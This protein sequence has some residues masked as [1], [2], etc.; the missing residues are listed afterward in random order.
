MKY[1]YY[2]NMYDPYVPIHASAQPIH[3]IYNQSKLDALLYGKE[4]I[5]FRVPSANPFYRIDRGRNT[6]YGDQAFVLLESLVAN[7]G[8]L[9]MC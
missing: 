1:M 4:E 3:W 7:K 6:C 2:Q 5:E 9:F 8:M